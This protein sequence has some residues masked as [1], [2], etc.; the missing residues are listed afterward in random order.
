MCVR[1]V[2]VCGGRGEYVCM[3]IMCVYDYDH[4]QT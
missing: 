2:S 4:V 3:C 1:E